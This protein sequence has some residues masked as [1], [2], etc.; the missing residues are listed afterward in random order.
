[1]ACRAL[2][3]SEVGA[4]ALQAVDVDHDIVRENHRHFSLPRI[5]FGLTVS[6]PVAFGL[7]HLSR[8]QKMKAVV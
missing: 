2:L 7:L 3:L 6:P 1:M 4:V 8:F 5:L